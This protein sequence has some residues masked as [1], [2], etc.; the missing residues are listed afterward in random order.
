MFHLSKY[1]Y[2]KSKSDISSLALCSN[3]LKLNLIPFE[4]SLKNKLTQN[5]LLDVT[6]KIQ[7]KFHNIHSA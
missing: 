4:L 7:P 5:N 2:T 3:P 1:N 6:V